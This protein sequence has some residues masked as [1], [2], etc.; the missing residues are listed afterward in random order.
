MSDSGGSKMK[1]SGAWP[2]TYYERSF[3]PEGQRVQVIML[4]TRFFRSALTPTDQWNA[5]GRERYIPSED[6]KQDMLGQ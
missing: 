3:G 4:D 5:R 1:M 2:G 6:P